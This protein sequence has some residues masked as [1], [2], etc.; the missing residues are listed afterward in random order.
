MSEAQRT[1][2]EQADFKRELDTITSQGTE[3]GCWSGG[4][5]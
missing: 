1:V 3:R 5:G 2:S 4:A